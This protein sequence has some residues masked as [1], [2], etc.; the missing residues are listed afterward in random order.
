MLPQARQP[1][2]QA[3]ALDPLKLRAREDLPDYAPQ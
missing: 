3:P 2:E 1:G